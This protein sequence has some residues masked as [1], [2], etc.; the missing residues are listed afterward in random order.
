MDYLEI[1]DSQGRRRHVP[2]DRPH[3]LIGR[4]SRCDIHLPHPAVSRRHAQLQSTEEGRWLLQDLQSRN[5]VYLDNRPVQQ[6]ILEPGK[7]VRIAQF[8]LALQGPFALPEREVNETQD[9][10]T[11]S[12]A[13]L[14]RSWLQHLQAFQRALLR[15][16]DPRLVL[17]HLAGEFHRVARP[18][19][20]AVGLAG[21][22]GPKWE[23]VRHADSKDRP[24]LGHGLETMPQ[25][26]TV[27]PQ[28]G[29]AEQHMAD[30][31]SRVQT[32]THIEVSDDSP[33]A[34]PAECLL[35]P[36]KGRSGII[37]H[38]YVQGPQATPLPPGIR[39][40]LSMAATLA[41][42][43]WDNLHLARLRLSQKELD[44]ELCRAR[45]I[46][47]E[48]LPATFDLDPRIDVFGVNL[49]SARVSGD[50]FDVF[51]LGPDTIAFLVADAMGHGMPAALVMATVR[52][53]LRMG[54][55]LGLSWK[56]VFRRLDDI[57]T[58]GRS[59]VFVTGIVGQVDL[60]T[61]KLYLVT[62]G[63]PLPSILVDGQPV[64]VPPRAQTRPWGLSLDVDWEVG[65]IALAGRT[66]SILCYTDGVLDAAVRTQ[67]TINS[68]RIAAYH[69]AHHDL[70]AEDLCQGLLNE[71]VVQQSPLSL[72]DDQTA[73]AL[74]QGLVPGPSGT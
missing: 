36:M 18:Q 48:L 26:G 40:Y 41:G 47:V 44:Q 31:E 3:L 19:L 17:E 42:L 72:H 61:Q 29:K 4:E 24:A 6:I 39:R 13:D 32:W 70:S 62:A 16:E 55:S 64:P 11:D 65:Q 67:R 52:A 56:A 9:E 71:F 25:Q 37:G 51:R 33:T 73:L 68:Q 14:D 50:Y 30:T 15:L 21:A 54:L 35:F 45:Q 38:V 46:Q 5:H 12:W 10:S 28:L 22:G 27:P 20:L 49:P 59:D 1:V 23:V 53:A 8:R 2:L 7:P 58:Q 74:G 34:E 43:V 69:Q 60:A 63:H 66:W 57:I